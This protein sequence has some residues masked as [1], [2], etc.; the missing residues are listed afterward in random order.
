MFLN[1]FSYVNRLFK[2]TGGV[3]KIDAK[4]PTS[5]KS[6]EDNSATTGFFLKVTNYLL[7]S[8]CLFSLVVF[9]HQ[10]ETL[11]LLGEH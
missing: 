3:C 5:K 10:T 6:T 9:H 11:F 1:V 7:Y 8:E 2:G 4:N